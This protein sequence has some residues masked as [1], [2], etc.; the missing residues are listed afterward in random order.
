MQKR[1]T[2]NDRDLYALCQYPMALLADAEKLVAEQLTFGTKR[3]GWTIVP[4]PSVGLPTARDMEVYV[5]MIQESAS[6]RFPKTTTFNRAAILK[7]LD[8]GDSK[9]AVERLHLA[10]KRWMRTTFTHHG[11]LRWEGKTETEDSELGIIQDYSLKSGKAPSE[12]TWTD[13]LHR[14]LTEH[15]YVHLD[16]DLYLSLRRPTAKAVYRYLCGR[17]WSGQTVYEESVV[18]FAQQR[19]GLRQKYPSQ[20]IN[21]L[22][23][24]LDDLCAAGA[25]SGYE[26]QDQKVRFFFPAQKATE[27]PQ[28]AE[29]PP[30]APP[31]A[32]ER[33]SASVREEMKK[34]GL[35]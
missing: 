25:L 8:W 10:F 26:F 2:P 22:R 31:P 7:K 19:I 21:K 9:E 30:L 32:I 20:I 23:P 29:K 24:A 16:A 33:H 28:P 1:T 17:C 35:L 11:L 15:Q 18:P 5:V 6:A 4:H 12:F 27:R 14:L 13:I 3:Q 34:R